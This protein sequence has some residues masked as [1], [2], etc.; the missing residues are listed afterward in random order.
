MPKALRVRNHLGHYSLG[1]GAKEGAAFQS[2]TFCHA[3]TMVSANDGFFH[4]QLLQWR[5]WN[6][7]GKNFWAHFRHVHCPSPFQT[8]MWEKGGTVI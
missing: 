4:M 8:S 3:G 2:A 5:Y 6:V 1:E 7:Q